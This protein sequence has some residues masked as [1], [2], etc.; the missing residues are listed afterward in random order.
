MSTVKLYIS[1][2]HFGV[3]YIISLHN[4][5]T[6]SRPNDQPADDVCGLQFTITLAPAPELDSSRIVVGRLVSGHAVVRV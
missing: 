5:Y 4:R 2:C 3:P 1:V 6:S